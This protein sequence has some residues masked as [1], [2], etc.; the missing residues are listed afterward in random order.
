MFN[1]LY[2]RPWV[3][4]IRNFARSI[5]ILGLVKRVLQRNELYE[6]QFNHAMES[7]VKPGDTI[8]DVGA[9]I[10][11][12]T[13][14]FLDWSGKDG[15]VVAF[16]P[17][18]KA[19]E[20]LRKELIS[21]KYFSQAVLRNTALA[22]KSGEAFFSNSDDDSI[23]TTAHLLDDSSNQNGVKVLVSTADLI[24]QGGESQPNVV[25]I[26]V[27]GYE[28]EVLRGGVKTFSNPNCR[29]ILVEM[30]FARMAERKLGNSASRIATLL[31]QWGYHIK[32]VDA[33]H[34]HAYR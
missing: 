29:H 6:Q 13:K 27:E 10:G 7:A 11:L 8:W 16:E 1:T 21:H 32:W 28:E 23:P 17:F 14:K 18:P 34:I 26:D 9:N 25:K 3:Q 4:K 31:K 24:V 2:H 30:H 15:K 5:G 12:Y 22:E 20:E 33:S 19:F